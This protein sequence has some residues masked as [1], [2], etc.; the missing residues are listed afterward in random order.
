MRAARRLRS[1]CIRPA[2]SP[3]TP[4]PTRATLLG[5]LQADVL[6][7][8]RRCT[9]TSTRAWPRAQVDRDDASLQV[10]ACHTRL[11]EVQVLH[12]QLRALLDAPRAAIR[13]CSRAT[14]RCS[15]RT[16]TRTRRT[17]R[18]C[19]AAPPARRATFPTRSPTPARWRSAPL[20]RRVPAPARAAAARARRSRSPRPAG[21]ARRSPRAS[22]LDAADVEPPAATGC[23]RPARAG[24]WT[25]RIAHASRR[26][27]RRCLHLRHSRSTACCSAM[28]VATTR[29]HRRR[30][31]MAGARRP[32]DRTA[33]DAP[34]ALAARAARCAHA[35]GR[36]AAAKPMARARW[37]RCSMR[38][39][40]EA[41]SVDATRAAAPARADRELRAQAP[42][43]PATT[44]PSRSR[45]AGAAA[46]RA[47]RRPMRA[48]RSSPAASVSGAWC[49]CG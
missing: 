1:R 30:R 9:A 28:P 2:R 49:R 24:A 47:R 34:A 14:S 23:S 22:A 18:R 37:R 33:L 25:R 10:H 31:A 13:R 4:S 29:R 44:R 3:P 5:R 21:G 15:R 43:S 8:L 36:R 48:R 7:N 35:A 41:D 40:V 11:R 32:G 17:S 45:R 26:R 12:D 20:A 19:S 16:S 6:D 42:N 46:R 39:A 27:W 38:V